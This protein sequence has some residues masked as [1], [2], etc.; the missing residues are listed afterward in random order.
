M[1]SVLEPLPP[2]LA[3]KVDVLSRLLSRSTNPFAPMLS[4]RD[5]N[6]DTHL[7][8][9]LDWNVLGNLQLKL[10]VFELLVEHDLRHCQGQAVL[11]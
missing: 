3:K 5:F 6:V 11:I 7:L 1:R 4:V 9:V 8:D 2:S 10:I